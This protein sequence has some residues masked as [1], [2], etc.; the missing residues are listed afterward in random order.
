MTMIAAISS[1]AFLPAIQPRVRPAAGAASIH[2]AAHVRPAVASRARAPVAFVEREDDTAA[3]VH[4]PS[5]PAFFT[6]T[7][8]GLSLKDLK[9]N[10][11]GE[12]V[13]ENALVSIEFTASLLSTGEVIQ[14]T[15]SR[16]VTFQR[17]G[18]L[19]MLDEAIDGM[20]TGSTRRVLINPESKFA[21]LGDLG[22]T[23]DFEITVVENITGRQKALYMARRVAGG[24]FN[25]LFWYTACQ[26]VL[27]AAGLLPSGQ[28]PV[29]DGQAIDAA[30]AWAAAGLA[31]V[32][33]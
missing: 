7:E 20:T 26:F 6:R 9:K 3:D 5:V 2:T 22:E 30:N 12:L 16:L 11:S 31:Q 15:G 10:P 18:Q 8:S 14:R 13:P 1:L 25:L 17:G 27:E 33:L 4:L 19:D 21:A 29:V 24:L 32:G 23:V 28:A